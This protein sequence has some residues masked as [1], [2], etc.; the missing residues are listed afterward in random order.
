MTLRLCAL[1]LGACLWFMPTVAHADTSDVDR[2]TARTLAQEGQD[3]LDDGDFDTARDRFTRA[4]AIIHAPTL[5]IGVARAQVGLGHLI[6]A[7]EAYNRILREGIAPDAPEAFTLALEEARREVLELSPRVPAVTIRVDGA[8]PS[9]V[10]I[11]GVPIPSAAIGARRPVDP[12]EHTIR[13]IAPGHRAAEASIFLAEG[14][15][16][17]VHLTLASTTPEA[18]PP[19]PE[20]APLAPPRSGFPSKALGLT[21]LGVGGAG[22]VLG[23]VTGIMALARHAALTEVCPGDVCPRQ[24][25][26]ARDTYRTLGT[27]STVGFIVGGAGIVGGSLLLLTMPTVDASR[28]SSPQGLRIAPQIGPGYVGAKGSF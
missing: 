13:A 8:H 25:E 7:Q 26:G 28:T 6:E 4:D 5:L 24:H 23:G 11:D 19:R 10:M 9:Q 17:D 22:I 15:H 18:T 20:E 12:G 27:L 16:Q 2:A 14:T 21:A 1:G 3:A